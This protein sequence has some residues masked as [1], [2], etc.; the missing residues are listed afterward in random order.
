LFENWI[1]KLYN[2]LIL[3][4][5]YF[6]TNTIK[7]IYTIEKIANIVAKYINIY[8]IKNSIYFTIQKIVIEILWD[9]Y[10]D[11]DYIRNIRQK[12]IY[13][14]QIFYQNFVSFCSNFIYLNY[15]LNYNKII[16]VQNLEIKINKKLR[17]ILAN[18]FRKFNILV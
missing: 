16:F 15:I 3:N 18:N 9:I 12:Y 10:Q 17:N 7:T 5:N 13:F 11:F 6:E 4:K 8:R 2:K 14:K 1:L